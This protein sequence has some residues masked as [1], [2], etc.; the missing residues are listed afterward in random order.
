MSKNPS[1]LILYKHK[2]QTT[3][4]HIVVRRGRVC[5]YRRCH[6]LVPRH[7]PG[8][9]SRWPSSHPPAVVHPTGPAVEYTVK[10]P[11]WIWAL[12]NEMRN[13]A[14]SLSLSIYHFSYVCLLCLN[15]MVSDIWKSLY[16]YQ[17]TLGRNTY[18]YLKP[19]HQ[20]KDKHVLLTCSDKLLSYVFRQ[21]AFI[22]KQNDISTTCLLD[23]LKWWLVQQMAGNYVTS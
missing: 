22:T 17:L 9:R 16:M 13:H 14:L 2:S 21:K 20:W 18:F 7:C 5:P 4:V 6:T 19:I 12:V 3:S 1:Y 10:Q 23:H 15:K 8:W 11:T